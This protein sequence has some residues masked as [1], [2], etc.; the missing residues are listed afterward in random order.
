VCPQ[1]NSVGSNSPARSAAESYSQED[2]LAL[3]EDFVKKANALADQVI[4]PAP[5][6]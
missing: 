4:S 6:T 2:A 1:P 3:L 5:V